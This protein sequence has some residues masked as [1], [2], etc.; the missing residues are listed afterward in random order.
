MRGNSVVSRCRGIR[1]MEMQVQTKRY[2]LLQVMCPALLTDFKH[3][4]F[5]ARAVPGVKSHLHPS[6]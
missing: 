1:R 5:V 4:M 6:M 3:A 2:L